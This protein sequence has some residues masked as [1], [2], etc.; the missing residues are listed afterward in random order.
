MSV[1]EAKQKS[2][3]PD[4]VPVRGTLVQTRVL[5]D[6]HSDRYC[7]RCGLLARIVFRR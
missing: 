2:L 4:A 1:A 7:E 5:G 3:A 6:W